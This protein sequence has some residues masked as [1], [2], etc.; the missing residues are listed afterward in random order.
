VT[1]KTLIIAELGINH[2]GDPGLAKE[3]MAAAKTAGADVAK[4]HSY[5]AE[6]VMTSATPLADYMK[7]HSAKMQESGFLAMARKFELSDN[8]TESLKAYAED[9]G[10]EFLSSPFDVTSVHYLHRLGVKRLKIPSGELVNP[11]LLQAAAETCLPLIVS[12]GMADIEEVQWAVSFLKKFNCGPLSLLHCLTQYP[13]E[14]C[15]VNLRALHTMQDA[16]PGI[17]I[18]YSD[19]TPGIETS[20]AAVAMGA[21]IIEKHLTLDRSLPGPDQAA[22]LIPSEFAAMVE[23]IRHIEEALGNGVKSPSAPEIPNMKIVRKSL[24]LREALPGGTVLSLSQLSAKR[25]G[26]GIPARELEKVVGR[27]TK[28]ALPA[29]HILQWD[30]LV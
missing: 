13:A 7:S 29:N 22:S 26:T 19:H 12:T 11:F 6:E 2:N 9:I 8:S 25:P 21:T 17:E 23:G 3:I 27:R 16:F 14:F 30:E 5:K 1:F 28:Q 20:I 4:I 24:V 15:H 18:G 10:I